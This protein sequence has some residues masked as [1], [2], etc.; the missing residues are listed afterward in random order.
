MENVNYAHSAQAPA[1]RR[2]RF[3]VAARRLL[4]LAGLL[5]CAVSAA[6]LRLD[7]GT[8]QVTLLELYTSQ[9][10]SSCPPAERWL[11]GFVASEALWERIVP[12]ALHVDYWDDLGWKDRYASAENGARQRDLA[13][14]NGSRSVYTPGVLVNGREWRGW[15]YGAN[16]PASER[17]PGTLALTVADG[18]IEARYPA[19][20]RTL[21]LNVA[22]LGFGIETRVERGENRDRTLRQEFVSLARVQHTT[23]DGHW[24]VALPRV[25]RATAERYA[26][27]AWVSEAGNPRPLQATGGWLERDAA[28]GDGR[29]P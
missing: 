7:S 1:D 23:V 9:G 19:T 20:G 28:E 18:T 13:R 2:R 5:A 29:S 15:I 14:H 4:L 16:P 8:R 22:L 24:R 6:E 11:K 27:A 26:I 12:L 17:E 21:E 25:A 10:C 3:A